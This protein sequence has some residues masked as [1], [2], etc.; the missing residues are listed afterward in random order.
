MTGFGDDEDSSSSE[1][2]SSNDLYVEAL[3]ENALV[4]SGD[5]SMLTRMIGYSVDGESTV[6]YIRLPDR[7]LK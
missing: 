4:G 2:L 3:V 1:G 7:I 6:S 5:P